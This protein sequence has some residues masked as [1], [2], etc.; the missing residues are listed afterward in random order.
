[1]LDEICGW[2]C[3]IA[4]AICPKAKVIL[5]AR[6][7]KPRQFISACRAARSPPL[8]AQSTSTLE[9]PERSRA[10]VGPLAGLSSIKGKE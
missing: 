9:T 3:T 2:L 4:G 1:M 8:C 6:V 10:L 5:G 7:L